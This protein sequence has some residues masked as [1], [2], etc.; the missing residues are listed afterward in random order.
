MELSEIIVEGDEKGAREL[1]KKLLGKGIKAEDLVE[2]LIHGMQIVGEKFER[3]EYFF[4]PRLYVQ[5]TQCML[6]LIPCARI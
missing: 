5:P 1:T 6:H 2:E 3:M 4:Y